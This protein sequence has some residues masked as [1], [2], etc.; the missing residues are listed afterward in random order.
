M[1]RQKL[2]KPFTIQG[3]SIFDPDSPCFG[4]IG[5]PMRRAPRGTDILISD[6][7][8]YVERRGVQP[9]HELDKEIVTLPAFGTSNTIKR[10]PGRL[11]RPPG[12]DRR[13]GRRE[14]RRID[15][16][17]VSLHNRLPL[18]HIAWRNR[19]NGIG[20]AKLRALEEALLE[21]RVGP[22]PVQFIAMLSD[23]LPCMARTSRPIFTPRF[24][25]A[26]FRAPPQVTKSGI[27]TMS[28]LCPATELA[29][30]SASR[31]AWVT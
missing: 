18:A 24:A 22:S 12:V 11:R 9:T 26:T 17:N 10:R 23:M 27:S 20:R 21:D 28:K 25:R 1:R 2:Q 13:L 5:Q 19:V 15:V 30:R 4:D 14:V 3:R 31:K 8:G 7:G 6:M 29:T 16:V